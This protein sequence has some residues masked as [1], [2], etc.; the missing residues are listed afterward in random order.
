MH[1][2]NSLM[3]FDQQALRENIENYIESHSEHLIVGLLNAFGTICYSISPK[4][5]KAFLD[6]TQPIKK[7]NVFFPGLNRA[8]ENVALD[9]SMNAYYTVNKSFACFPPL[10]VTK[11][12]VEASTVQILQSKSVRLYT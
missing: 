10:V 11:N 2:G 4:G 5:A 6:Q 3:Y 1:L 9:I 8:L 12:E 7:I